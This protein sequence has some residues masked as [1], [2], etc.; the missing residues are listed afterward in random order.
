MISQARVQYETHKSKIKISNLSKSYHQRN[1]KLEV[2]SNVDLE[3]Q[4][5]EFLTIVG[6]SGCG[7]STLLRLIAG[8]DLSF[9]GSITI[10]NQMISGIGRDRGMVFQDHRL[11]PWMNVE[12]N[13]GFGL[14]HL[15]IKE[16]NRV[17]QE[18]IELVGLK[19]FEK[20]KPG[21]LSGGMSQRVAIARTL[22]NKPDIILFDE[23]FGALDALTRIQMQQEILRIREQSNSTMILV[24]HDID[25]AV[26][27]GD[28]VIVMSK[29]PGRIQKTIP[30]YLPRPRDRNSYDFLKIREQIFYLFF[31]NEK[32]KIPED[33]SI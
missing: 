20:S 21:E 1:H 18:H 10:D 32:G 26:L 11:F 8:L 2:L 16:R 4:E 27:L 28:R 7:K 25:E 22:V 14:E 19:G 5:G 12:Q 13:I 30:V 3:V 9:D 15:S 17:V 29:K 23:P 31:E 33:F 6:S 24:T